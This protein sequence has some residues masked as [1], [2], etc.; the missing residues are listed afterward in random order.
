M[1][2]NNGSGLPPVVE[3]VDEAIVALNRLRRIEFILVVIT[4]VGVILAASFSAWSAWQIRSCT[5]PEGSCYQNTTVRARA[6]SR[7]QQSELD[8]QHR[9]IQCVLFVDPSEREAK[10]T[11]PQCE[12]QNP[13]KENP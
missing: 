7:L 12:A 9:I 3:K 13:R 10:T 11:L 8:R 1:T 6:A 5:T 2:E 4:T